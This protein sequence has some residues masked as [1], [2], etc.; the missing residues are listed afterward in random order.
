VVGQLVERPWSVLVYKESHCCGDRL[1]LCW[2][3]VKLEEFAFKSA[4]TRSCKELHV[5]PLTTEATF[6]LT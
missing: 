3:E 1:R 4:L 2:G 6:S 5:T